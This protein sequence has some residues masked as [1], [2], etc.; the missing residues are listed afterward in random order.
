[1][2][3]QT[4]PTQESPADIL[5][6]GKIRLVLEA[7]GETAYAD[8]ICYYETLDLLVEKIRSSK[9]CDQGEIFVYVKSA[10]DYVVVKQVAPSSCEMMVVTK[11][12]IWDVVTAY[13]FEQ[14]ELLAAI[15]E[16]M[17]KPAAQFHRLAFAYPTSD[18]AV[19]FGHGQ[20]G[21]YFVVYSDGV[22]IPFVDLAVAMEHIKGRE[23]QPH[24][25]SIDNPA[26]RHRLT[27]QQREVINP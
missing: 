17:A 22:Q 20:D 13:R 3:T 10:D 7:V 19:S 14:Q 8:K 27:A 5:D 11:H 25:W 12:G 26:H 9:H 1:M 18:A 15:T 16:Q 24:Y 4:T 23:T 2:S 6:Q 21:C